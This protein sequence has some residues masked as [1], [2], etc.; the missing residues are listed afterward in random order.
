MKPIKILCGALACLLVAAGVFAQGNPTGTV[1]GRVAG[2]DGAALPGATVTATS[3]GLQGPR[4]VTTNETGDYI[5]PFLPPGEYTLT[6]ELQGFQTATQKTLVSA[7]ATV[8]LD[9][10]LQIGGVTE[11][12]TVTGSVTEGFASGVAAATTVKQEVVNELP[13]NRGLDQTVALTP[14]A[15]RTGPS[16]SSTGNQQIAISGA[17]T[18][19]NLILVNGVVAQDNVRRTSLPLFIEDALQETTIS[20]AGVSAEFGRFAGGVVNAIT[21]S[22]GNTVSGSFRTTFNNDSWRALTP[23]T[24]DTT[25]DSLIPTY[26]Y[27]IGGPVLHDRLWFFHAGRYENEKLGRNLF[28]PVNTPYTRT[29]LRRRFEG[30]GTYSPLNGH[31]AKVMYLNN[32]ARAQNSNFQNEMDLASLTDREDPESTWSLNYTATLTSKLFIEAQY[33]RHEAMIQG[34]GAKSTDLIEGTLVIDNLSAGRFNSATFCGVCRATE[35]DNDS[36]VVK[37]SYFLSRPGLG[38]HTIVAGYDGF[39]D[40]VAADNHQSGSGYRIIGTSSIV[41]NGVVYPVWNNVG[42]STLIRYNPILNPTQGSNYKTHSLFF[43]DQ[44]RVNGRTTA[45]L[46]VRYDLNSGV[47]SAGVKDVDDSK[48]SPRL[49]LAYDLL[50]DGNWIVN[51]NYATYVSSLVNSIANSGSNAGGAAQF[52]FQYLGPGINLDP[53]AGTL[54]STQDALRT[55]FD[56]FNANGGTARANVGAALP[57]VNQRIS[58]DLQS[59]SADE[60]AGGV[61]K[62]LGPRTLVRVDAVYRKFEDFYSTRVDTSTGQ[63][64]NSLN[65]T[66]DINIIENTNAVERKYKGLNVSTSWRPTDRITV[67]G[68]YT[69]S[70]TWGSV[71]GETSA[72][73]PTTVTARF[74]P[75]YREGR[76]NYPI[77]DLLIDQRHKVRIHALYS[78][79]VSSHGDLTIGAIQSFNSGTPYNA[80][81]NITIA[82]YVPAGLPYR[83]AP[84]AVTYFFTPRDAFRADTS[85]S[86]DIA[87]TLNYRV[88]GAS[89]AQLFLKADVLNLFNESAIINP[90][91]INTGVLTNVSTARLAAFNPFTETPVQGV[92]WDLTPT[93]GQAQNRFAYQIPRTF[94]I[95]MGVRF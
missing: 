14:G 32:Y 92:H 76:W 15:L 86:T 78:L 73:G 40:K 31:T 20:T 85:S 17:I 61:T 49:G 10:K 48:V 2:Q 25:T 87:A 90:F 18:S 46:G 23:L 29:T 79:P 45:S 60:I 5:I 54:I 28:A 30:K 24:N 62:R 7:A 89:R 75:E 1:S 83:N 94:K 37:A 33:S 39:A 13:L 47:N 19:E 58:P 26:E 84:A 6:F 59:P 56:W 71:D 81:G 70:R 41:R 80:Q 53:N 68:A 93:F 12:I 67:G 35:R 64:T 36:M 43:N 22:G 11:A 65:Q 82:P 72:G 63:V 34:N 51:A 42:S 95:A 44:W 74:Y 9:A 91:F 69:L 77:G 66:F 21:K 52:D 38:T 8:P 27:T 50:G 55:L 57:G 4:A 3:P 88:P 16:N